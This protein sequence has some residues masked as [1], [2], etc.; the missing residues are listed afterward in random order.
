MIGEKEVQSLR[1]LA[2]RWMEHASNPAMAERRR[3]W[4]A[5]KD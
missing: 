1:R 5:V 2:S 4:Q 3:Q